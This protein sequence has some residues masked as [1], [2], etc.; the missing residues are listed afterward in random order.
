MKLIASRRRFHFEKKEV[1]RRPTSVIL[2]HAKISKWLEKYQMETI[3]GRGF[4]VIKRVVKSKNEDFE[5]FPN[6]LK[7]TKWKQLYDDVFTSKNEDC[8]VEVLPEILN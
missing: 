3:A 1:V 8:D 5:E 6:G 2:F 4:H 7:S